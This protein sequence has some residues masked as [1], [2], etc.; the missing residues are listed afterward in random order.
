[1]K[2]S[3]QDI[4]SDLLGRLQEE[5][6]ITNV[7]PGSIARTFCEIL[8]E[9]FYSFYS[10]LEINSTMAFVS[11]ANGR[12]LDMMGAL[13]DCARLAGEQDDAYR[14][15]ITNQVYTVAGG[16]YT[17]IRLK[18]LSIPGVQD[19]IL[20]EFTHGAGS[21]GV[22][23]LTDDPR[24]EPSLLRQV[25]AAIDDTK[26]FGIYAEVKSPVL[27]PLEL[28]VRLVFSNDASANERSSIRQNVAR[29]L[30]NYINEIGM[31]D[32]FVINEAIQRVME[33]SPKIRDMELYS[34]KVKQIPRFVANVEAKWDERFMLDTLDIT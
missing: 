1:M 11:T 4:L 25:Q 29:N 16:N 18:A 2:K 21:F 14:A 27:I 32:T 20:R 23:V 24:T 30:K 10:Q 8:T 34:L 3:R 31:G 26:S 13:L 17:A 7:D 15:R 33:T 6:P 5:T 22:Y 28:M 19:V 12:Y 9:E